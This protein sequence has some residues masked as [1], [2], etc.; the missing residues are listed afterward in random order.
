MAISSVKNLPESLQDVAETVGI[1]VALKLI[2]H[3]GGTEIKFPKKPADDHPILVALGKEDGNAVCQL[4]AGDFIYIPHGRPRRSVRADVKE[5][6]R[7]GKKRAEIA[8]MLGI[9][10]RWV[11]EVVND[12]PPEEPDLFS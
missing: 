9:S 8:R 1:G 12:N 6:D 7:Q 3:F 4:L 2:A 11:R 5:L 10:Q